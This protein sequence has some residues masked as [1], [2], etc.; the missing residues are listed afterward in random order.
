MD[1]AAFARNPGL[2][3]RQWHQR[4]ALESNGGRTVP[5][6]VVHGIQIALH[7]LHPIQI[8]PVVLLLKLWLILRSLR[9]RI[10][11]LTV[12]R[13]RGNSKGPKSPNP[14]SKRRNT[15]KRPVTIHST[16]SLQNFANTSSNILILPCIY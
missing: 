3:L 14:S 13:C 4:S 9:R 16:F 12:E 10:R 1:P 5:V 7:D 8:D 15:Q 6:Q 11:L 2:T